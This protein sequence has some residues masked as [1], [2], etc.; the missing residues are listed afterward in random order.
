MVELIRPLQG[1]FVFEERQERGSRGCHAPNISASFQGC[2]FCLAERPAECGRWKGLWRNIIHLIPLFLEAWPFFRIGE[3]SWSHFMNHLLFL[4]GCWHEQHV[5]RQLAPPGA[6]LARA[7][8]EVTT[9]P[10][11]LPQHLTRAAR[12][13]MRRRR[14]FTLV[15]SARQEGMCFQI[16]RWAGYYKEQGIRKKHLLQNTVVSE[17]EWPFQRWYKFLK[18]FVL[19]GNQSSFMLRHVVAFLES[20]YKGQSVV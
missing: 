14:H 3:T 6:R 17:P 8:V 20:F 15:G 13:K 9:H 5:E 11:G 16:A 4:P 7:H 1:C 10:Q 12:R 2:F 18:A 19:S